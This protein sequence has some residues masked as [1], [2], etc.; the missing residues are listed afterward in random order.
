MQRAASDRGLHRVSLE[1]WSVGGE[2]AV[3]G[4]GRF[5]DSLG[6]NTYLSCGG[7]WSVW[8][9]FQPSRVRVKLQSQ[10]Q[11]PTNPSSSVNLY[12]H[13]IHTFVSRSPIDISYRSPSSP[14]S[15]S[16]K[17]RPV[18]SHRGPPASAASGTSSSRNAM[19]RLLKEL[20]TWQ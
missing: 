11:P 3:W 10:R 5:T 17:C 13:G 15:P 9:P 12:L 16:C 4:A 6:K 1:D 18:S 8:W 7:L 20:D 2:S 19:K 14:S